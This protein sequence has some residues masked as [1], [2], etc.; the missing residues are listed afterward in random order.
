MVS[1]I[2]RDILHDDHFK[3]MIRLHKDKVL[4]GSYAS[5]EWMNDPKHL[6]FKMSRYKFVS[7][8]LNG[9]K[10]VLEIGAG[11]GFASKIVSEVVK[12]LD[13]CDVTESSKKQY[14]IFNV[15]KN[16]YFIHNFTKKKNS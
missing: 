10:N 2:K 16:K 13:L 9:K 7:K 4:L 14:E 1:K 12:N 5:Y 6:L 3:K 15:E 8:M 11:D